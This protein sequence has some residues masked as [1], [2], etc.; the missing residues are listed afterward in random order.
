[1]KTIIVPTDFSST[2]A[3][4]ASYG[5]SLADSMHAS[6]ALLHVC[7]L[8]VVYGE[9]PMPLVSVGDMTQD[10]EQKME[11]L[12]KTLSIETGNRIKIY[13]DIRIGTVTSELK[14]YCSKIKPY[15]V[16]LGTHGSSKMERFLFGSTTTWSLKHLGWP[17]IIVPANAKFHTIYNIGLACDFHNVIDTTPVEE[18][19]T[20]V[21]DL[22]ADL[23]V[24]YINPD[25]KKDEYDPKLVEESGW[26]QEMLGDLEPHYHFIDHE[27]I[28]K[29]ISEYAEKYFLDL[30]IVVPKKHPLLEK[31]FQ[32]SHTSQLAR[33]THI[34]LVSIHEK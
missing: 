20:L 1:M 8:P 30:L 3:N 26:L 17:L 21:K 32:P 2:A 18:I 11:E 23:H 16:V 5:A 15:A 4:A 7:T 29:G 22:Q 13:S 25:W 14:D 33:Q 19:K 24:L 34:P 6:L 31:L 12:K 27:D 10:A 28:D 9:I